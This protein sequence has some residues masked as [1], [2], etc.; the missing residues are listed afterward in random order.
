M[1]EPN[2]PDTGEHDP[3]P[4]DTLPVLTGVDAELGDEEKGAASG[5]EPTVGIE[6]LHAQ[7]AALLGELAALRAAIT[8]ANSRIAALEARHSG[9]DELPVLVAAVWTLVRLDLPDARSY[10]LGARTRIGRAAECEIVIETSSVSRHHALVHLD[11]WG[12]VI[13]DLNSTNGVYVNGRKHLRA[14]LRDGDAV[15][16]GEAKFRVAGP[17][18]PAVPVA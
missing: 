17:D 15:T 10:V 2:D 6:G 1:R 16:I 9:S 5:T 12:A 13:E 4:T 14:R 3:D 18:G 11:G 8:R 7:L